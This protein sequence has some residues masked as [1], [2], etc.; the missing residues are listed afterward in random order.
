M[1]SQARRVSCARSAID[2]AVGANP[3]RH[4]VEDLVSTRAPATDPC[5]IETVAV[6]EA[7]A[8][9][10]GATDLDTT[11]IGAARAAGHELRACHDDPATATRWARVFHQTLLDS[12]PNRHL[13]DLIEL[14]SRCTRPLPLPRYIDADVLTRIADDHEAILDLI[15]A[16]AP[17]REIERA[18]RD[19]ASRSTL[20][21][22][23]PVEL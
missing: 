20:C 10:M 7:A 22:L 21:C 23:V 5:L 9:A 15:I 18:L 2:N 8:S 14:E 6:L 12:C 4:L 1:H 13:L 11:G 16:R 3:H 19:H 17:H